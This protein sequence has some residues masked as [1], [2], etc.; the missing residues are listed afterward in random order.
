MADQ[1]PLFVVMDQSEAEVRYAYYCKSCHKLQCGKPHTKPVRCSICFTDDIV[2]EKVDNAGMRKLYLL[3]FGTE[4]PFG[5][6]PP[7]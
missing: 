6:P 3:R 5:V 1:K 7:P 4:T 2:V